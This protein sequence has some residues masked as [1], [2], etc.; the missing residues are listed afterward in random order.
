MP[1]VILEILDLIII[2]IGIVIRLGVLILA[3]FILAS[4]SIKII[5]WLIN[6]LKLSSKE[7]NFLALRKRWV[8]WAT[9]L[10]I[11]FILYIYGKWNL[12]RYQYLY[13]LMD[14]LQ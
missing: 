1:S 14:R 9:I 11:F 6:T 2:T 7:V 8:F 12:Y 10:F 3:S 4:A 5:A 13:D